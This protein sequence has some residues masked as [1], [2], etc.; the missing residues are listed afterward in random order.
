[1]KA[2]HLQSIFQR[3][4]LTW[5][6]KSRLTLDF[7]LGIVGAVVA[8]IL[9]Q[10]FADFRQQE[11]EN[12]RFRSSMGI[13]R[14]Y[15]ERYSNFYAPNDNGFDVMQIHR[16]PGIPD[17]VVEATI[18]SLR[19]IGDQDEA[20]YTAMYHLSRIYKRDLLNY[21]YNDDT[22]RQ[23]R[24]HDYWTSLDYIC[25]WTGVQSNLLCSAGNTVTM[26]NGR[27]IMT[28]YYGSDGDVVSCADQS[29]YDSYEFPEITLGE[30]E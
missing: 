29:I 16:M 15:C 19:V 10:Y 5:K 12:K 11:T 23:W 17:P 24:G 9:F 30:T 3:L 2:L 28:Y 26:R 7:S 25:A 22:V 8:S 27:P 21:I 18:E 14:Q 13:V 1:M 20:A 6:S 4:K